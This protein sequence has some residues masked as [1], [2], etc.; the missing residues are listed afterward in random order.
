[1]FDRVVDAPLLL[2]FPLRKKCLYLEL[3]WSVLFSIPT[4]IT[5]NKDTFHAASF[6]V[7]FMTQISSNTK[8]NVELQGRKNFFLSRQG[9]F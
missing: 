8:R 1:M 6:L 2:D 7:F 4:R 9:I 5:P 3:F